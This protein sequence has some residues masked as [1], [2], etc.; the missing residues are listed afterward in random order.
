M[1]SLVREFPGRIRPLGFLTW[2]NIL[3]RTTTW[4]A[5]VV[6]YDAQSPNIYYS[7]PYKVFPLVSAGMS[8]ICV[9]IPALRGLSPNLRLAST[10]D[11]FI[12]LVGRAMRGELKADADAAASFRRER[13]WDRILDR[14]IA[15][16]DEALLHSP[17]GDPR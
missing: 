1:A 14:V 17:S 8:V 6:P 3:E 9:D 15:A 10:A 2:P 13:S 5:A 4:D 12:A 16:Y 11:E 7:C